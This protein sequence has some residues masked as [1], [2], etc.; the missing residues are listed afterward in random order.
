MRGILDT[1]DYNHFR[2]INAEGVCA[3][4]FDGAKLAN[5]CLVGDAIIWDNEECKL[6]QRDQHPV[7]SGTLELTSKTTY[8]VTSRGIP[9]Y[10]FIPFRRDYPPFVVG[11][12]EK[13]KTKNKICLIKFSEWTGQFPRGNLEKVIGNAGDISSETQGLV[14]SIC[15]WPTLKAPFDL[16]SSSIESR[17]RLSGYTFNIDPPGCRDIDDVVTIES[18]EPHLWRI[19]IT[20]SDVSVY[21]EELGA[22]D[23]M[24]GTIGQTLYNNG[25][26]VK[27]MLP[28]EISEDLCSLHEGKEHSGVSLII[29]WNEEN[30][31][32]LSWKETVFVNNKSW[33]YDE[34]MQSSSDEKSVLQMFTSSIEKRDLNDSHEWIET[35]MKLYNM[36]AG[37]LLKE[38]GVGILRRH[39]MPNMERLNK[40]A[41]W[42]SGLAVLAN[43]AAEYCDAGDNV[44]THYG[45]ESD[46]YCHATSPIRRYADLMNQRILKELIKDNRDDSS[47]LMVTVDIDELN[48]RAKLCK[49]FERDVTYMT[50]LQDASSF[51]GRILDI[52]DSDDNMYKLRIF[53]PDWKRTISCYYKKIGE[54]EISSQD[55]SE[56]FHIQEGSLVDITCSIQPNN[57]RW[58][59]RIVTRIKKVY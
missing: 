27:P 36:E 23:I 48:R 53:I 39:S 47:I 58:K 45:L 42:D 10:L 8:G 35:L 12:S 19:T 57:R 16:K 2:V 11:C 51:T 55:E 13:N 50:A 43:S 32:S 6:L 31:I 14:H 33:T 30:I 46:A 37:K 1:T 7:I 22:V 49:G 59:E 40:Y 29:T 9:I 21:I 25:K 24:A 52:T 3:A 56:S 54:Y 15:P 18:V 5:K 28:I 34:F 41:K 4:E 20:I 44:T 26:A 38:A 17:H